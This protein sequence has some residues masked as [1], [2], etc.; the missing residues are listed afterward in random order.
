MPVNPAFDTTP[1]PSGRG[2]TA[3][4]YGAGAGYGWAAWPAGTLAANA[5]RERAIDV[6]K[7]SFAEGRLT[8]AEYD[9]RTARV[10]AARTYGELGALTADLPIGPLGGPVPY[11]V[12]GYPPWRP[13]RPA[14]N[15]MAV[16][17]LACGIGEFFTMGLTAIP[18]VVLGL[19]ARRQLRKTG[20]RGDGMALTGLILGCAGIALVAVAIAGLI[21]MTAAAAHS[22]HPVIV[23][24]AS[25]G[26]SGPI[27]G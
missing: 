15:P 26:I 22:V 2:G 3:R 9:D 12:A 5:D 7:A 21:A 19:V 23:P 4:P 20:Q 24:P 11:P 18:A 27:A 1:A 25:G 16:A 13:A 17:A 10:Y 8:K 6:L 14:V